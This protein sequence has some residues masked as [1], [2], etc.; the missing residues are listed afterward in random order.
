MPEKLL[1]KLFNQTGQNLEEKLTIEHLWCGRSWRM[2]RVFNVKVIDVMWSAGT[3][4][5]TPPLR[6]SL[7]GTRHHLNN[8][9]PQLLAAHSKKRL[10]I[11]STLLKVIAHKA[12]PERPGRSVRRSKAER[13]ARSQHESVNAVKTAYPLMTK[14]RHELNKQLQTA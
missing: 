1:E 8:F 6:L 14:S 4:Y 3:T 11:Y 2:P 5:G 13:V 12:V 10:Q 9:I 7:Q